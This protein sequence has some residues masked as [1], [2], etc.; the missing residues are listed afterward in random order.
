LERYNLVVEMIGFLTATRDYSFVDR[1]GNA[2]DNVIVIE[3][4][5]DALRTFISLCVHSV[6]KRVEVEEGQYIPCPELNH[7]ELER[8]VDKFLDNIKELR[9]GKLVEIARD[10]AARA[11]ASSLKYKP[12]TGGG[13]K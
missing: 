13:S 6:D 4:V 7:E 10:L 2:L 11:L 9:G 8:Q 3:A 12:Q 1:V 5:R